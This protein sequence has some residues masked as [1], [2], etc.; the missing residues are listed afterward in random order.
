M[1]GVSG[2]YEL[3]VSLKGNKSLKYLNIFNNKVGYDGAK[4]VA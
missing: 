2:A 1:L 4:A 3:S